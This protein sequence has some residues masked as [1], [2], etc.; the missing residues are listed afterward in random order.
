MQ[1]F[2]TMIMVIIDPA[3]NVA[4]I[5]NAGH[6]APLV[7]RADGIIEEPSEDIAGLPLGVTD[8]MG[9]EQCEVQ[10]RPGDTFTM[11]TDGINESIDANGAFYTIERL[12]EQVQKLGADA[13]IVGP[14]I[15]EDGKQFLGKAPQVD[16]MCLVCFGRQKA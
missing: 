9:Y 12:R 5:V 7:R 1:R 4:T 13:K 2:V 11:Y 3:K 8:A 6:M 10:I 14:A 16:D 15:V